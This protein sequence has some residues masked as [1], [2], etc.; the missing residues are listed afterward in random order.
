MGQIRKIVSSRLYMCRDR[1]VDVALMVAVGSNEKQFEMQYCSDSPIT[2]K[3]LE[4]W[5]AL[6]RKDEIRIPS[7]RFL[8]KKTDALKEMATHKLSTAEFDTM[9]AKKKVLQRN[10]T[11]FVTERS[12]LMSLQ[13]KALQEGDAETAEKLADKL[14]SLEEMT[15]KRKVHDV[16]KMT[17]VNERNRKRNLEEIRKAEIRQNDERRRQEQSGTSNPFNR[18]KTNARTFYPSNDN[19][20]STTPL[21]EDKAPVSQVVVSAK[22]VAVVETATATQKTLDKIVKGKALGDIDDV[23]AG[24]QMDLDIDIEV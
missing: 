21:P 3:E 18:L 20:R 9:I 8:V 19:S 10:P 22:P 5:K 11:N 23:I 16:D 13:K 15:T 24:A 14:F 2:E 17:A 4:W 1:Q 7:K 6:L 12:T